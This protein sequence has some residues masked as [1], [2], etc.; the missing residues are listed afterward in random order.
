MVTTNT[1]EME[2][3][4]VPSYDRRSELNAFDGSKVGVQGL[5][6]NGVTKVPPIFYTSRSNIGEDFTTSKFAIPTIDL[7]GIHDDPT[8]RDAVVRKVRNAC[9]N[10]GFFQVTN[11]G[12]PTHVLDEM[13]KGISRF[14]EQDANVRKT[15]YTR[16]LSKK[17]VYFSNYS[18][19]QDPSTDWR[20][21]I[22]FFWTPNPPKAQELPQVCRDIVAEYSTKVMA[23]ASDLFELIS[24]ALGLDHLHLK[25]MKCE[26]GLVLL[27]NYYPA[28]PEP[29]LCMGTSKHTDGD[30]MTILL[31]DQMGGLQIL[32][33]NQWIDV[34]AIHGAL[35]VNIGDLLQLVSNDKFI[36]VEHR[37]LA[38]NLG[39]R[40]S[41]ASFFGI[42]DRSEE[43]VSKVFG[44]IKELLSENNPPVYRE[45]S[46]KDYLA[47]QYSK[48]LGASSIS[49]LKL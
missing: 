12:I 46:L 22:T 21:T 41:I 36:S 30:F 49:F 1:E 16:D 28:C 37:V 11:H 25:E 35:V 13:I 3:G 5:V 26:E 40:T 15:Y 20:D 43:G 18:L 39:P 48:Q 10:W 44:P 14:H 29:E 2:A 23:L 6:E 19:F 34:P 33:Q 38:N 31:Q 45:T 27:G 32:H 47:H 8:L 42:G 9:E 17:V 7:I 4:T 24:E